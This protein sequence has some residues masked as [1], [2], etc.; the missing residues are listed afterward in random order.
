M[1]K[2]EKNNYK[3]TLHYFWQALMTQKL[4]TVLLLVLMPVYIFIGSVIWPRGTSD[5]IG[6]LSS[7]DFDIANY[8]GVLLFTILP[9]AFNNLVLVRILDFLDWS[10]DAKCGKYLS[11]LA[12]NAVINQSMTFH[13]DHFSGSLTSQA[14]KLPGAFIDLKSMFVWNMLPLILRTSYSL[15]AAM[16]ISPAFGAILFISMA[17]YTV[18]SIVTYYKTRDVD[19]NLAEAENK[20]TGQLADAVT[21]VLNVKSYAR[22]GFERKRFERATDRTERATFKVARTSF[23]RNMLM[24][25]VGTTT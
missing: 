10:L 1:K 3:R 25:V 13:A 24:N 19:E 21:N 5:I 9:M 14:N 16:V 23:M 20:Q 15:I 8:T 11:E 7:G 22:E 4:R 18:V 2:Q 17:A 6:M 12:F